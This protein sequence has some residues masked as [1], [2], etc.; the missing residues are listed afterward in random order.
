VWH[1]ATS[2]KDEWGA[3]AGLQQKGIERL[4]EVL[5]LS[6]TTSMKEFT[7]SFQTTRL[8]IL[9]WWSFQLAHL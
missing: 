5:S 1:V 9:R 4:F 6:N 8:K 2:N 7:K 3:M